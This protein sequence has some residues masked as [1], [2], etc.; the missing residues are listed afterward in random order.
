MKKLFL[1][2]FGLLLAFGLKAQQGV[3][4]QAD[5]VLIKQA[6]AADPSLSTRYVAY[7][8][9]FKNLMNAAKTDTLIGG[10]RIIPVVFHIIHV[11]GAENISDDQVYD[12]IEKLNIDYNLQ[13]ADTADIY[14]LFK[15]RAANCQ[16]EFR[17]ARVD[18]NGNCTSGIVH[19]FDPQT[20]FA[21]FN[22][23]A[24]YCWKPSEYMNIFAVNFIYPEGM[25]LPDGAFIGGMS[26]FPPS[27]TLTQALTGG[28][29][30]MDGVLIRQDCIGTIGTGAD[31]AGMGINLMNRTFT[32][33]TGHYFN[34][35][36]PFQSMYA[37]FGIDGCGMPPLFVTGDEVDDTPPVAAATQNTSLACFTP[38]SINSCNTDD[39]DEPDMIENYMDYQFG[40]CTNLFSLGQLDRI[41]TTLM[42]DRRNLWSYE[43]LLAK[44]VLDTNVVLCAPIAD[45]HANTHLVCAG[46]SVDFFDVSFNGTVDTRTWTFTGGTP[47]TS[48][49]QYPTVT[50]STPGVYPVTLSVYNATGGDTVTMTDYIT[51]K[52]PALVTAAPLTESFETINFSNDLIIHSDTAAAWT[53]S[54][55]ACT[56]SKAIYLN[57]F[58]GN[59]AGSFDSFILPAYDLSDLGE[60]SKL[61]FRCAYA[62]KYVAASLL[63][64]ADTIYDKLS[65]LFS[66]DCGVTWTN[67][68]SLTGTALASAD[69]V[70][71]AFSPASESEWGTHEIM[72]PQGLLPGYSNLLVKFEFYSNGG[73]N[74]YIDDI[75]I[76]TVSWFGMEESIV[77]N[78]FVVYPNPAGDET[79]ISFTLHNNADVKLSVV[80]IT[81]REIAV[82]TSSKLDA[83][84]HQFPLSLSQVKA[85]GTYFV[86]L[87]VN[88]MQMVKT[89]VF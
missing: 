63:T 37:S 18:T 68:L 85:K 52:D 7:E 41:N 27:N 11:Y 6:A 53:Q 4:Y 24:K 71:T 55:V 61:Q 36:H 76:N 48:N 70:E 40:Y 78:S 35:Y 84:A 33:E 72:I 74:M 81:G 57:N 49:V 64:A 83:G 46:G 28:D 25:S 58:D 79:N 66:D 88:G 12:A 29:T 39:P 14:P 89:V 44:G 15:P 38:G 22:T 3:L 87:D 43:N 23:M 62:P 47:A 82:V 51:V 1:F 13:N 75:N 10:K 54:S 45:F 32:H 19:H 56:G 80:D 5:D 86:R 60:H 34:L 31:M 42:N 59:L 20:N 30:L 2:S 21:Y 77:D 69:P 65:I 67:K 73:N 16:I 26:P 17:L 50:Y 8:Q 9:N